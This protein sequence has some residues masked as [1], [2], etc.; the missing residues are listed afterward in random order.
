MRCPIRL[1]D[2]GSG[3]GNSLTGTAAWGSTSTV[4]GGGVDHAC[5][6]LPLDSVSPVTHDPAAPLTSTFDPGDSGTITDPQDEWLREVTQDSVAALHLH[7]LHRK[8]KEH[9]DGKEG[10]EHD[11]KVIR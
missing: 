7:G 10:G 3:G 9:A 4:P 1:S 5:T 8:R 6:P 2:V 11:P